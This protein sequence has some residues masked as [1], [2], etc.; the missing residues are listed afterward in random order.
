MI[1]NPA[2]IVALLLAIE[3]AVLFLAGNKRT[4]HLFSF[5]P[6]VFW[7]YF[8]P[9]LAAT[10]GLIDTK[11]PVFGLITTYLLPA[12]LLLLLL[13][14]DIR[15]IWRLGH[16]ALA[17][18]F[19]GA[20]GIIAGA[21][22]SFGI[23]RQFV[24]A[25]FWSG[26]GALSA[27]WTGGSA[28]MIAVKEALSVPDAVFAPM[29][30]VDTVVPYLWMGL[31]IA[32]VALQ[33][34]FDAWVKADSRVIDELSS[35]ASA[36]WERAAARLTAG[37]IIILLATAAAG[38][39]AAQLLARQMPV[40]KDVVSPYTWVIIIVSMM[41]ILLSLTPARRLEEYG[42]SRVG[43]Y[44]LYFVLTAI[45][46]KASIASIGSAVTLIIAGFLIVLVHALFLLVGA[47]LMKAPMFLVASASQAN[48]GG[49]ASAP[50]VAEVYQPGL[51]S[52]GLLLAI[53][54]NILGTYMGIF[55]AQL[56]RMLL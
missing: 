14:V 46:A 1:R 28:N 7:I 5:L 36:A 35:Q 39:M 23:F 32:G 22:L 41:G 48:I 20:A 42:S 56:C 6:S 12:S 27:S 43:Y 10:F 55:C 31:L 26:F 37:G 54:G 3:A 49:V 44:I 9:M 51:A 52:V 17:M 45:G 30:I 21:V 53:L 38:S 40:V 4:K 50:V 34:G 13:P 18:F 47:R 29:V 2:V 24:G 8:I 15:A 33:K 16:T 11:N 25:Q 19:I